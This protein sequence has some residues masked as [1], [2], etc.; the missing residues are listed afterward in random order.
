M[1][2]YHPCLQKIKNWIDNHR[3]GKI[4][5]YRSI[6]GEYL[7]DWHPWED[8]R[9]S[10]ASLKNMGGGPTLTL[11]HELDN[12]FWLFGKPNKVVGILNFN[13]DLEINT[14][15]CSDMLLGYDSGITGN[16]HLDY[17]QKP[18]KRT[19]EI[20]GSKGKVEF[21]YYLNKCSIFIHEKPDVEEYVLEK[22]FDRNNLFVKEIKEFIFCV[23]N[24][25]KSP[26]PI[27]EAEI[28]LRTALKVLKS[29]G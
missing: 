23:K 19:M 18:P 3:I 15:H 29:G 21:D 1:M 5:S 14:E 9:D 8:Y 13:S 6:W 26:I 11:S 25:K 27:E 20:L 4:I 17:V 7:P 12:A 10:Y 2:R 22:E 16:I 28:S 24:N